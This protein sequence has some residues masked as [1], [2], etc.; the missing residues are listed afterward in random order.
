MLDRGAAS[1]SKYYTVPNQATPVVSNNLIVNAGQQN[2][3]DTWQWR[4]DHNI[5][6]ENRLFIRMSRDQMT[7]VEPNYYGNIANDS[8]TYSGSVQPDWHAT[9]SDTHSFRPR[10]LLDVRAGYARNG[11]DR[12]PIS[13]GVDPTPLRF[14]AALAPSSPV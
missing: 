7:D 14:P 13:A 5:T 8:N 1:A 11:F 4:V 10:T 9:V 6:A 2:D 3:L 12:R